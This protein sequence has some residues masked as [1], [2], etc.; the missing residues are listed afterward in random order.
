MGQLR[1]GS[2]VLLGV[3][4]LAACAGCDAVQNGATISDSK[5][6]AGGPPWFVEAAGE[7]GL[8]FEHR[9]GHDERHIFPEIIG[10]GA[11]L[12]DMDGDGDLDAYLVQSGS[13]VDPGPGSGVNR[14]FENDGAGN[15]RDVT[16]GSGAAD[17]GYGMGVATGDYDDDGDVDLYVTNYG[18]NV[19]LRNDGGGR[20]SDVTTVAAVGHAGWG[21]SAAFVD[22]DADGDLDLFFANY[23]NWSLANERDCHNTAWQPD[24]CLPTH[25]R[26]PA[27]DV[28]YRNDGGGRFTDVTIEA[29][30]NTAFGNGLG[31]VC[32]DFDGDGAADIFVA[33]D[34]ML[35]QLWVNRRD[36]TF[37]EESLTRGCALDEHGMAK[38]GMGVAAEDYDDD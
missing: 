1:R 20:F 23:V 33:N 16:E 13:L 29:D 15:F 12:F 21:T 25:Y 9:S 4:A 19:L 7:R 5:E 35:N 22:H 38:A 6:S 37:V 26:A 14:L 28:L 3:I 8:R 31:V 17:A 32:A 34:S 24:Y 11:A 30:L 18:P 36:G 27:A 2:H 10:G